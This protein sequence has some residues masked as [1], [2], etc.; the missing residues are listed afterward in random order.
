MRKIL[1]LLL[2]ILFAT[3]KQETDNKKFVVVKDEKGNVESEINY[4]NDTLMHGLAKYYY[5]NGNLKVETYYDSGLKNGWH[6]RYYEDGKIKSKISFKKGLLEGAS[7][8]YFPNG[9][10]SEEAN[11]I[12]N[13]PFGNSIFYYENGSVKTYNCFDF[14]EHNRYL[15]K[16][17]INGQKIKEEGTVLGQL[18]YEVN[19]DSIPVNKPWIVKVSVAVPP[20][21]KV[22][23]ILGK[24]V[25]SELKEITLLPVENNMVI[26]QETFLV[27]GKY[28]LITIGEIKDKQG[29][30]LKRDSIRTD[31]IVVD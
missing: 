1:Y 16:Y 27:K 31:I 17:D 6:R 19:L 3:C 24:L 2:F 20:N 26:Y 21:T 7:Q 9:K 25:K 29:F 18:L 22:N 4:I 12:N 28:T 10:V 13:K 23:V 11:W 5:K 30:V 8:W 14:Q 15:I